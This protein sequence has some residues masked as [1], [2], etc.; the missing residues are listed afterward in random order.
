V[1]SLDEY[2][3]HLRT[4][5]V[6]GACRSINKEYKPDA[7]GGVKAKTNCHHSKILGSGARFR[8]I[9]LEHIDVKSLQYLRH[10]GSN[11]LNWTSLDALRVGTNITSAIN[12]I[13]C[14]GIVGRIVSSPMSTTRIGPGPEEA[15][16]PDQK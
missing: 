6:K 11:R 9:Y 4:W 5:L 8:S 7:K 2:H 13:H 10:P 3:R 16:G 1:A 14:E 12:H 15:G